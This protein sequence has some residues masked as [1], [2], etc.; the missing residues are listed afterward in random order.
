[1]GTDIHSMVE[2]Y[3]DGKWFHITGFISDMYNEN[4]SLNVFNSES[5]KNASTPLDGRNYDLFALLANIRNGFGFAGVDTGDAIEPISYPKGLPEDA[6]S[7]VKEKFE[8]DCDLHSH[9]YLTLQELKSVETNQIK[10]Q[11]GFI[12]AK[13]YEEFL[14]TEE[15]H[16]CCGDV[17]GRN[18]IKVPKE[19]AIETQEKNPDYQVYCQVEWKET[20]DEF[21]SILINHVIPELEKK[22]E[23]YN[24]FDNEIRLVFCFDN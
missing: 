16:S 11:R 24:L 21:G 13:Q 8:D 20:I 17:S 12:T 5:Y 22:A 7:V 10:I 4:C 19:V 3:K 1:M 15:I 6:S 14:N 18:I 23:E 2:I 9:S